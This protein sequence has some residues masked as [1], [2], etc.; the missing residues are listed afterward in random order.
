[1]LWFF[2]RIVIFYLTLLI[3]IIRSKEQFLV[4]DAKKSKKKKLRDVDCCVDGQTIDM[5]SKSS[6]LHQVESHYAHLNKPT[7]PPVRNVAL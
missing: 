7:I 1:M 2:F 3:H 4:S 5:M 6:N